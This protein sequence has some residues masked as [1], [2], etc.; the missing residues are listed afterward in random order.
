MKPKIKGFTNTVIKAE[1]PD[2]SYVAKTRLGASV[3]AAE[4]THTV[5]NNNKFTA[6]D[7][8]LFENLAEEKAELRKIAS[9]SGNTT[10]VTDAL[11]FGHVKDTPI[12]FIPY[13]KVIF[14]TAT[15]EEATYA[16]RNT[17]SLAVD[18]DFTY[19]D[20][21]SGSSST[22]AKIR[23]YNEQ[24]T[25]YSEFSDAVQFSGYKSGSLQYLIDAVRRTTRTEDKSIVSDD[26]LKDC[27][28]DFAN[29][30][31]SERNWQF[32]E[33]NNTD[34]LEAGVQG[35]DLPGNYRPGSIMQV[36]ITS[37]STYYYPEFKPIAEFNNFNRSN[38]TGTIP[39]IFTIWNNQILFYPT[40]STA[41]ADNVFYRYS[42]KTPDAL[43]GP[44]S[45]TEISR[46]M[47][48]VWAG[49]EAV[50]LKRGD[51]NKASLYNQKKQTELIKMKQEDSA[52]QS[53][54][55]PASPRP[56]DIKRMVDPNRWPTLTGA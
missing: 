4:V 30:I 37:G 14:Y 17:A 31:A 5:V 51:L 28:N 13:N 27:F 9:I 42:K 21:T 33:T 55:F 29:E 54:A 52:R 43:S 6:D 8:V 18:S 24:G 15:G 45:V 46:Y 23:Y 35:Y 40:P 47:V 44:N 38:T 7:Y 39:S 1:H 22:W 3:S 32:L 19:Y 11:A 2:M 12:R 20:Y 49:C 25:S 41:G 53:I 48:L 56:R 34:S 26:E 50:E 36:R 10:I 16:A